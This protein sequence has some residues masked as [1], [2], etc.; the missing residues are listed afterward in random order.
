MCQFKKYNPIM[1]EATNFENEEEVE[2][3]ILAASIW[4]VTV[5]I[6]ILLGTPELHLSN[7]ESQ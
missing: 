6:T 3:V 7:L 2:I 4:G 5:S 1:S